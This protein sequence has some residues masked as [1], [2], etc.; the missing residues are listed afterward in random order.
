MLT[1]T[2]AA[3]CLHPP[4]SATEQGEGGKEH[5]V[6]SDQHRAER[7]NKKMKFPRNIK[8]IQ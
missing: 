7:R 3:N 5:E 2:H 4:P 8:I 6:W 1:T